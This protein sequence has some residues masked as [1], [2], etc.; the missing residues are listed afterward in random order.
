MKRE[1][2]TYGTQL[3]KQ[4]NCC[5]ATCFLFIHRFAREAINWLVKRCLKCFILFF[6]WECVKSWIIYSYVQRLVGGL[7]MLQNEA[8]IF[9]MLKILKAKKA[10]C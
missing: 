6:F 8:S 5:F 3:L 10:L 7:V 2:R 4:V 9:N 1:G